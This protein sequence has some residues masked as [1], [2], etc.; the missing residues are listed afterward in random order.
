MIDIHTHIIPGIDDGAQD[1]EETV[2]MAQAAVEEGIHTLIATPHHAN[3]KYDNPWTQVEHAVHEVNEVLRGRG[4]PLT[5]VP[6]QE[7]R[8]YNNLLEDL[9]SHMAGTLHSSKYIL[10][11]FPTREIPKKTEALFHELRVMG[12]VP[13][14]AH[15]ER[16]MELASDPSKLQHLIQQGALAQI[17]S[18]SINGLFGKKIQ[19]LSFELCEHRMVHFVASDAHNIENR[20]FGL[21][22]AYSMLAQ[23][24]GDDLVH[25]YK[26]NAVKLISHEDINVS[27]PAWKTK[28]WWK[29]WG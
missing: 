3:G 25:G 20:A 24:F 7:I 18:H 10:I 16:N 21:R 26:E 19:K 2:Q 17:T 22:Q 4:I 23:K 12:L 13:V 9:H 11:E 8:V 27:Q 29:F 28:T 15:P 5:V 14:I 6:G 1:M